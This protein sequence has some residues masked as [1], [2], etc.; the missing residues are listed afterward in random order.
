MVE[1]DAV[2]IVKQDAAFF[3]RGED[4]AIGGFAAAV[5]IL[6]GVAAIIVDVPIQQV[7]IGAGQEGA[8]ATGGVK[9]AQLGGLLGRFACQQVAQRIFDD[10]V[11]NIGGRVINAAGFAHFGFFFD[12]DPRFARGA[13]HFDDFAEKSFVDLPKNIGG[14]DRKF[15]TALRR[16]QREDDFLQDIVGNIKFHRQVI[17]RA[18]RVIGWVEVKQARV[19][20]SVGGSIQIF[21][22]FIDLFLARGSFQRSIGLEVAVFGDAQEDDAVDCALHELVELALVEL[23]VDEAGLFVKLFRQQRSP[24]FHIAQ[25]SR[26]HGQHAFA[27]ISQQVFVPAL[28]D[29]ARR[30]G[31]MQAR[32]GAGVLRAGQVP[33]AGFGGVVAL[34]R[35]DAAI[36]NSELG[37]IGQDAEGGIARPAVGAQLPGGFDLL[38]DVDG[39]L[40]GLD[41]EGAPPP[42]Q[43][44]VIGVFGAAAAFYARFVQ[45]LLAVADIPAQRGKEGV[46]EFLPQLRFVVV[47]LAI[48]LSVPLK[49]VD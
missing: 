47:G 46:N 19:V 37:E 4:H 28:L 29:G 14:D 10:V 3:A 5:A 30:E 39:G 36:V 20:F 18:A 7:L 48:A 40:F 12:H 43:E 13:A 22:F 2:D 34:V 33:D 26:I 25:E 17:G 42:G 21:D 24:A 8:A 35:R 45:D 1:V 27:D 49:L 23:A 38:A 16:I 32:P 31:L 9:R 15:V 6:R 41:I 44:A 11:N